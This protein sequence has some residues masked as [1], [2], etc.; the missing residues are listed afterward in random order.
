M[1]PLRCKGRGTRLNFCAESP[2]CVL[3][4]I[5][6]VVSFACGAG[7]RLLFTSFFRTAVAFMFIRHLSPAAIAKGLENYFGSQHSTPRK[8]REPPMARPI[9]RTTFS[10][11]RRI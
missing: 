9:I 6:S 3:A 1:I 10:H 7:S 2:I 11:G 5:F 8:Y 4:Q